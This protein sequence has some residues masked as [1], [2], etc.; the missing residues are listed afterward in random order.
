M[1][2]Q[3]T[4]TF[5]SCSYVYLS[6]QVAA[7]R[8]AIQLEKEQE[9]R[10]AAKDL[11]QLHEMMQDINIMLDEQVRS[12][13]PSFFQAHTHAPYLFLRCVVPFVSLPRVEFLVSL[14]ANAVAP[15]LW[16][17]VMVDTPDPHGHRSHQRAGRHRGSGQGA[18][19]PQLVPLQVRHPVDR[20]RRGGRGRGHRR[21]CC[22][23]T[24]QSGGRRR[25]RW[26]WRGSGVV[27]AT[28]ELVER[29]AQLVRPP[30]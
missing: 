14:W 23:R 22:A 17:G 27:G 29:V 19:V 2:T 12:L 11:T 15:R 25:W 13:S 8:S 1:L 20:H 6:V 21:R 24:A 18:R 3:F 10:A 9:L 5:C 4:V 26:R 16:Q 7:T 28:L 30:E